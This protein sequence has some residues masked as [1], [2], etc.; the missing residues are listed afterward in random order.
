MAMSTITHDR[1]IL[2]TLN[3][4]DAEELLQWA[5][6]HH[7]AQAGIV[8]SFQ[9]TG[10]V[11]IDMASRATPG[12]RVLTVDTW[13]L[14]EETYSFIEEIEERYQISVERYEPYPKSVHRMIQQHGEFLFFDSKAKQEYCCHIR[15]VEPNRRALATLDVWITGL[16]KDQS[17]TRQETPKVSLTQQDG[18]S[19]L[20][21]CP[22]A[23]WS[24]EDVWAYIHEHNVPYNRLY[25]KGYTSIGCIICTTP[26]KPGEDKRAGRWRWFNSLEQSNKEC[27]IHNGGSGI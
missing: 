8:T 26:T 23:E 2:D 14:H 22:L 10:C 17:D 13:R 1:T 4:M 20:K 3:G 27:G 15:K 12:L 21:L 7:G 19:L 5:G 25:D 9:N 16:R 18:R 11:M 6:E 24:E